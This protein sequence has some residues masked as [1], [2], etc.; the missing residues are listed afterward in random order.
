MLPPETVA[1]GLAAL[2]GV[3]LAAVVGTAINRVV[4]EAA[5]ADVVAGIVASLGVLCLATAYGDFAEVTA[6][7][8]SSIILS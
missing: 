8:S 7:A 6:A 1:Q 5:F 3:F 4:D 2:P